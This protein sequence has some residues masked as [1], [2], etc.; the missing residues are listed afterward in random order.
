M[1]QS[2]GIKNLCS[3]GV[4]EMFCS[5]ASFTGL[6]LINPN[7]S[8]FRKDSICDLSLLLLL[9]AKWVSLMALKKRNNNAS[10]E[11]LGD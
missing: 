4:P 7:N 3:L 1:A 11:R 10:V 5:G 6:E 8:V 2:M 9:L